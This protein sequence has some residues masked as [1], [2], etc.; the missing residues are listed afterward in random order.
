MNLLYV[1][2]ANKARSPTFEA[3]TKL[4]LEEYSIE[5]INVLSAGI[6][7]ARMEH[8]IEEGHD[9]AS[10]ATRQILNSKG[11]DIDN[12]TLTFIDDLIDESDLILV[13]DQYTVDL[14]LEQFPDYSPILAG[15]YAGS[16]KYREV[17][18]PHHSSRGDV[19]EIEGY[20]MMIAEIKYLSR[21]VVKRLGSEK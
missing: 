10:R 12:H 6:G 16:K 17:F 3:Y 14:I 4:F 1:C 19:T 7:R 18:G 11:I 2:Y 21:K 13:S 5:G 20:K 9:L 15:E 8:L